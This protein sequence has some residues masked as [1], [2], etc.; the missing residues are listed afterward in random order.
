MY[1][2]ME[3][4]GFLV[5][6]GAGVRAVQRMETPV[7]ER[8]EKGKWSLT[9]LVLEEPHGATG[10]DTGIH[11]AVELSSLSILH[12]SHHMPSPV[13]SQNVLSLSITSNAMNNY[14]F[15]SFIQLG[16][17]PDMKM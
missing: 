16:L 11:L 1:R 5:L 17:W 2:M 4:Q 13:V 7:L 12:S 14:C 9:S 6:H 15:K 10:R 8:G 3:I